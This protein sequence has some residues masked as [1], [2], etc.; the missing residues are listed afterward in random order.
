MMRGTTWQKHKELTYVC[1]FNARLRLQLFWWYVFTYHC[2]K[3]ICALWLKLRLTLR[4]KLILRFE[5][6]LHVEADDEVAAEV[7]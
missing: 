4:S 7:G 1:L 5:L 6:Q 2:C 3:V